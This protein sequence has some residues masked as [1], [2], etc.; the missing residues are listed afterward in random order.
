[1]KKTTLIITALSLLVVAILMISGFKGEITGGAVTCNIP[2]ILVG[3]DCCLDSNDNRICD[4]DETAPDAESVEP[5][6]EEIIEEPKI[7][8]PK[9]LPAG[10]YLLTLGD[11][12]QF[13]GKTITLIGVENLPR[14]K[15]IYSVDGVERDVYGT[16]EME[17]VN[18]I[19][20]TNLQYLNL[21]NGFVLKLEKLVLGEGEYLI[22]TRKDL[23]VK[24]K[25]LVLEDVKDD[26]EIILHVLG[27][28]IEG[29]LLIDEE[30]TEEVAGLKITNLYGFPSGFK[31]DRLAIIKVQ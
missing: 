9:E 29:K 12:I 6:R 18:G 5:P 16:K 3:T 30:E 27:N 11:S 1:M 14:V 23:T 28:G 25:T 20:I 2:Y 13:E 15:G 17:L 24:G 10:E 8:A 22:D 19:K 4:K 26:G 21:E 7:G 31:L